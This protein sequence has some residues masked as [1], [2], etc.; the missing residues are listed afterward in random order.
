MTPS[1]FPRYGAS[2]DP[3]PVHDVSWRLVAAKDLE[4]VT[5][6][7]DL[8]LLGLAGAHDEHHERQHAS[9]NEVEERPQLGTETIEQAHGDGAR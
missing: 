7:E 3:R 1:S 6:Q 2:G 4:L 8:D 5:E 9:D